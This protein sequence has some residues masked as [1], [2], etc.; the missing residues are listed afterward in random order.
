MKPF[1]VFLLLHVVVLPVEVVGDELDGVVGALLRHG[2]QRLR[3]HVA[4]RVL[5]EGE[6]GQYLYAVHLKNPLRWVDIFL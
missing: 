3:Q 5:Q 4:Q 1:L 6:G 2:G